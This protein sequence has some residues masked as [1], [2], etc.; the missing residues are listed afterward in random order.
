MSGYGRWLTLVMIGV[1]GGAVAAPPHAALAQQ[2]GTTERALPASFVVTL[3]PD[4]PIRSGAGSQW[5]IGVQAPA[6]EI[7]RVQNEQGGWLGVEFPRRAPVMARV[8]EVTVED[9]PG[10]DRVAELDRRSALRVYNV[11]A[12]VS[13]ECYKQ[14]FPL[15]PLAAGTRM[16][17]IGEV[18]RRAGGLGGYL[19]IPPQPPVGY[20]TPRD[21]RV[22]TDEEIERYYRVRGLEPPRAE[23]EEDPPADDDAADVEQAGEPVED[24]ANAQDDQPS[25]D[26]E[27][28]SADDEANDGE[29]VEPLEPADPQEDEAF[30]ELERRVTELAALDDAYG[31]VVSEP[32]E[33]AELRPLAE[34]Y[35]TFAVQLP[36]ESK[37]EGMS[38]AAMARAEL[39]E[40]RLNLQDARRR[41]A[42]LRES[43]ARV[44]DTSVVERAAAMGYRVV[45]RLLPSRIYD[46]TNLPE[47]F[48]VVS[49]DNVAGR[50]LAYVIP[51]DGTALESMVGSIVGVRGETTS[52][53][54]RRVPILQPSVVDVLRSGQTRDQTEPATQ[55]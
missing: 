55:E 8:D 28:E 22:A 30:K 24:D 16:E 4:T 31:R 26:D 27:Q 50:T 36:N 43:A 44:P 40:I 49:V 39:L 25:E 29:A 6:N 3:R 54:E 11:D 14:A 19:V 34:A 21:V 41:L 12:E 48:R 45:G 1:F 7:L 15:E 18:Q 17:I 23:E 10:G 2:D 33:T 38:R 13:E 42:D 5:Y 37:Y 32:I 9:L 20:V 35:R 53:Q 52:Q 46:G 51:R 47:L